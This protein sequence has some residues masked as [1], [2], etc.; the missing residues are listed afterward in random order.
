LNILHHDNLADSGWAS[1]LDIL[2]HDKPSRQW[3]GYNVGYFA[4]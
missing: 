4:P 1:I 2:H 3:A